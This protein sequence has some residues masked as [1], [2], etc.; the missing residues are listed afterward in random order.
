MGCIAKEA[1]SAIVECWYRRVF[2]YGP[3]IW[4]EALKGIRMYL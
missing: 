4:L 1:Y 2:K 3:N